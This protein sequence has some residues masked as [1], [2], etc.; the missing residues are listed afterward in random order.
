MSLCHY[1]NSKNFRTQTWK[2][3][4]YI[5][6][7]G[8][9]RD[10]IQTM[11]KESS[12]ITHARCIREGGGEKCANLR[13]FEKWCFDWFYQASVI[14]I[15]KPERTHKKRKLH[16]NIHSCKYSQQNISKANPIA[17]HKRYIPWWSRI[18]PRNAE[19][20]QHTQNNKDDKV[21]Q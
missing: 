5:K 12:Y 10:R 15:P 20:I 3:S 19:M 2:S 6:T 4:E 16:P 17:Y 11:M 7:F 9:F 1:Q 14:L 13:N 18:Y 8:R 21:H